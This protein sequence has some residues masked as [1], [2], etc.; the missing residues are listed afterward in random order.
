MLEGYKW[1]DADED[2]FLELD[3][4]S[5]SAS[6][7][8]NDFVGLSFLLDKSVTLFVMG[9]GASQRVSPWWP[10]VNRIDKV[11]VF[12]GLRTDLVPTT[13]PNEEAL[14]GSSLAFLC[15]CWDVKARSDEWVLPDKTLCKQFP[16]RWQQLRD[17]RDMRNSIIHPRSERESITQPLD[18]HTGGSLIASVEGGPRRALGGV[19]QLTYTGAINYAVSLHSFILFTHRTIEQ[20][21]RR[22]SG[23]PRQEEPHDD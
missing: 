16:D 6:L 14:F 12:P 17:L 21:R 1:R 19:S 11:A 13:S 10:G 9:F 22:L 23:V 7:D 15:S 3:L 5:D 4:E 2:D 8:V 20:A 18:H